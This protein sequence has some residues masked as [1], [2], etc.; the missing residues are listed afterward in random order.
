MIKSSLFLLL[1]CNV[2]SNFA[3][4]KHIDGQFEDI[5]VDHHE[6]YYI[7][8]KEGTIG[9][10][11]HVGKVEQPI[12]NDIPFGMALNFLSNVISN[13]PI[14]FTHVVEAGNRCCS[15]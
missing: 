11:F 7:L 8:N 3:Q 13:L 2:L 15:V 14:G 10:V 12:T 4:E 5:F 1:V 6:H 9:T